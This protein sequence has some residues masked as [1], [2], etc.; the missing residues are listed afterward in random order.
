M[1]VNQKNISTAATIGGE[2]V[3]DRFVFSK[4]AALKASLLPLAEGVE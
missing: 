2:V 3:D 4:S 1:H